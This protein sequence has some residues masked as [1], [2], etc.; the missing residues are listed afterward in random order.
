[1]NSPPEATSRLSRW[2]PVCIVREDVR[3]YLVINAA[4]Y[5]LFLVGFAVGLM[6]P[7]LA[8]AQHTRLE[9]GGTADLVRSLINNPWLFALTILTVNVIR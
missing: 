5:G 3:V 6:F 1:M 7:H 2:R 4:A 9:D 8:Q